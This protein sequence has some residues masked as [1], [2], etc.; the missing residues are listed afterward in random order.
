MKK[1]GLLDYLFS[2][3]LVRL[4]QYMAMPLTTA[5]QLF[6]FCQCLS[7][8]LT[9]RI[10]KHVVD[11]WYS[12]HVRQIIDFIL[13]EIHTQE[14]KVSARLSQQLA[15]TEFELSGSGHRPIYREQ[16]LDINLSPE[17]VK[18]REALRNVDKL[19]TKKVSSS[20]DVLVCFS[21]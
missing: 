11:D 9:K 4:A 2:F 21:F 5:V 8:W 19:L 17:A 12:T 6:K 7:V 14:T 15:I 16:F 10:S 1:G 18:E 20:V 13:S 3:R